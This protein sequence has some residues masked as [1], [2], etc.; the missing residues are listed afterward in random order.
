MKNLPK[1]I[2]AMILCIT[3]NFSMAHTIEVDPATHLDNYVT[4]GE[5]NTDGDLEGW[6]SHN[7]VNV[8]AYDGSITGTV[9]GA[10]PQIQLNLAVGNRVKLDAGSI[11]E[12]R[13]KYD[14]DASIT[15]TTGQLF[16]Y[17]YNAGTFYNVHY[18]DYTDYQIDGNYHVYRVTLS[19]N[20]PATDRIRIDPLGSGYDGQTISIDYVRMKLPQMI[21]P[22]DA[23]GEYFSY[24][25]EGSLAEWNTDGDYEN[26]SVVNMS[27]NSVFGGY[28][29][30]TNNNDGQIYKQAVNGLPAIDLDDNN[31]VQV[32]MKRETNYVSDVDVFFG[33]ANNPGVSGARQSRLWRDAIPRDNDF[34]IYRYDLS[35]FST[36]EG[37][38]ETL[39]F[40]PSWA[41]NQEVVVDYIRIGKIIPEPATL[42]LLSLLGLAF[43]RKK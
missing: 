11:I 33:T 8:D 1:L 22:I 18:A 6:T 41:A 2:P 13:I 35:V 39:R 28:L 21:D 9:S 15:N 14:A 26:W 16:F 20:I 5:W 4:F 12:L 43:L 37:T 34:H 24:S 40:D 30:A 29:T 3:T 19:S 27:P 25:V 36:W 17:D 38:L 7:L 32:R 23:T 31:I 42:G 10:D